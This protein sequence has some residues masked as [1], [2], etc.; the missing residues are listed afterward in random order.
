MITTIQLGRTENVKLAQFGDGNIKI[1]RAR[2]Q[3]EEKESMLILYNQQ[4]Q[5]VGYVG[6]EDRGKFSDDIGEAQIVLK[7]KNLEGLTSLI[8][9][10]VELQGSML[11]IYQAAN[12]ANTVTSSQ[13]T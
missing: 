13:G 10:L 3:D 9:S 6:H 2:E 12:D 11:G 5:P 1:A 7:F 4:A 8:H